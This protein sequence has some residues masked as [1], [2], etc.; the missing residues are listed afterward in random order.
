MRKLVGMGVSFVAVLVF[1]TAC[2]LGA[3]D[4]SEE[5]DTPPITYVSE[6]E[7]DKL[8]QG[9]EDG[10]EEAN[11]G[12]DKETEPKDDQS[13]ASRNQRELYLIDANGMVVPQ[14]FILPKTE[15]TK[16]QALEY[17]VEGGP[18]QEMLP[19]GFRA[20]LPAGTEVSVEMMTEENIA[21]ANFTS[22]FN[23]YHVADE[24]A[25][26]E[27][28]TWTLTQ[29]DD[30]DEVK[31]QVDG[32]ELTAMPQG[33]TPIKGNLSRADGINLEASGVVDMTNSE[34]VTVYFIG[35]QG[36][37]TYYVPVTRRIE[38]TE[39]VVTAAV[40]AL[41]EGPELSTNLL[42]SLSSEVRLLEAPTINDKEVMLN[43]NEAI[44]AGNDTQEIRN[45]VLEAIALTLTEQEE[46]EA[47]T[48]TINGEM[49]TTTEEGQVAA[50]VTRP[51]TLNERPL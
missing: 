5:L 47:V 39:D 2:S 20:V 30:V 38:N 11:E 24:R 45:D 22:E 28:V 48:I 6:E 26:L 42:S 51:E 9:E 16:Q 4:Q 10:A 27:A 34:D 49:E 50:T 46:I 19:N 33:G 44:Q 3:S 17:L 23:D 40:N 29:F 7:A 43:F 35:S 18:I 41:I 8:K 37:D 12:T 25:L 15:A 1:S 14:T 21:V 32:Y 31:V 13:E 36:E